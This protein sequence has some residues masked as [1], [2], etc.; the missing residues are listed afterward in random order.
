VQGVRGGVPRVCLRIPPAAA[1]RGLDFSLI[2]H[3]F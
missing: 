3:G 1:I 2:L